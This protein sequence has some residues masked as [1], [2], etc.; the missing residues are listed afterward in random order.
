MT[1][2]F[3]VFLNGSF[4][5]GKST[6][7]EHL[8]DQLAAAGTPFALVD[9]DWFHRSWPPAPDDP[10]NV[11]GE[12]ENIAAVWATYRHAGPRQLVVSGVIRSGADRER[13]ERAT[14]LPVR[15]VRL[16]AD[17]ATSEQR[18]RRR[19]SADQQTALDWHLQRHRALAEQLRAADLD[20][21]ALDTAAM[22]PAQVA[23]AV[24]RHVGL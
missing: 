22:A 19:Y 20:E 6:V 21:L 9:V 12:A 5:V 23:G 11:L 13:Y 7:L 2:A 17:A 15:S 8:G 18:L 16:E 24:R 1:G 10:E 14:G 4:G 3:A